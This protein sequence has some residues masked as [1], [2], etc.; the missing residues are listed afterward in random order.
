MELS[1]FKNLETKINKEKH[2]KD[3]ATSITDDIELELAK[4]LDAIQ[5]FSVDRI[6]GDIVV[7]ENRENG[8][9]LNIEKSKLAFDIQE[10]DILKYV[11]GRYILDKEKT[12]SETEQI[13]KQ[14]DDLWN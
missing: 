3:F 1:F 4:K 9:I 8:K 6:E 12:K 7:L 14:M 11:N 10:G 13:K 5:E 2:E